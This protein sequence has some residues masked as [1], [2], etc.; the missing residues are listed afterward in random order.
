MKVLFIDIVH[1]ILEDRLLKMGFRCDH[2]YTSNRETILNKLGKYE[3]LVI[4][5]RIA[6]D[7]EF[8]G[9]ENTL[10]FIARSGAGVENID[11]KE[12][13]K[14]GIH[15]ISAPEGNRQAVGEHTLGMILSLFNKISLGDKEIRF[16]KWNREANRGIELSGKTIGIIGYGNMGK[17]FAKCL[18]GFDC[19]VLAYSKS[20]LNISDDYVRGSSLENIQNKADIISFH[21][22]YNKST[23][24]YLNENFIEK[25]NKPFYV[26][27]TARG[28]VVHTEALVKGLKSKK[29]LGACLDVL[30]YE[31]DCFEN[32]FDK[33]MPDD[34]QYLVSTPKVLLS[35]HVA[36]WTVE[37]YEKL[38][39]I[40]ADKI[41]AL[42]SL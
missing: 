7:K 41:E 6:V 16:G 2:D 35:P 33:N 17:A 27:N 12:A 24:H 32:M 23:H 11:C 15:L 26:I 28:K 8:L 18:S 40:L 1:P 42:Y 29:I 19:E 25:M 30:E 37:S 34:F 22:P 21:T 3:G 5:S 36:G 9:T 4:R 38:S 31:K 10:K 39:G 13:K 14:R 20:P